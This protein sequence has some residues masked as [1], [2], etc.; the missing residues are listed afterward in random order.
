MWECGVATNPASPDTR[1]IVLQC[2]V[3]APRVF[4]DSVRVN[5]REKEDV[6]KFAKEFL[7]ENT[8]F[9]G[10]GRA[11]APELSPTGDEVRKAAE[12][13]YGALSDVVP[14]SDVAEWAAQPLIQLQLPID[15][16]EKLSAEAGAPGEHAIQV[17][18]VTVVAFVDP[19]ALKIFGIPICRRRRN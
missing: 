13:L 17:A 2:S 7:T 9:P 14:K 10:I 12:A 15:I 8:F 18:D 19:Q 11:I 4:Q 3:Q 6:L 5:A 1:I 16:V